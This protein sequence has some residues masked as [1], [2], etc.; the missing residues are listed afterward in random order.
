M[1]Q[2]LTTAAG[3]TVTVPASTR[4]EYPVYAL[5]L[6]Q[7]EAK[8]VNVST[9]LRDLVLKELGPKLPPAGTGNA[10]GG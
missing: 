5:L 8:G 3:R 9:Y 1:E 7:V 6:K 10:G 2:V 4:L